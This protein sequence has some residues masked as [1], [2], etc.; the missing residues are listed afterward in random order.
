MH[1]IEEKIAKT[2]GGR[3]VGEAGWGWVELISKFQVAVQKKIL[4]PPWVSYCMELNPD[5]SRLLSLT[6]ISKL[7]T[8]WENL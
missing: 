8:I 7:F 5:G 4:A 6:V 2:C 3:G 1:K